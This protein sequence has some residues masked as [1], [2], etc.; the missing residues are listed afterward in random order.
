MCRACFVFIIVLIFSG[1]AAFSQITLS[2]PVFKGKN[3]NLMKAKWETSAFIGFPVPI[4]LTKDSSDSKFFLCLVPS[5][6]IS[7]VSFSKNL[8]VKRENGFTS[9]SVDSDKSHHYKSG[10]FKMNSLM[11]TSSFSLPIEFWFRTP[12]KPN[13]VLGG[14]FYVEYLLGGRFVNNYNDS[15]GKQ[16]IISKFKSN[17]EFYGFNRFQYGISLRLMIGMV[18]IYG[19]YSLAPLFK[20]N[21]GID[22]QKAGIGIS[23]DI[24]HKWGLGFF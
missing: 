4:Y 7:T 23:V 24:L 8:V 13:I 22:V 21:Q 6:H 2:Y 3:A 5:V 15:I 10:F 1:F 18:R 14:G 12:T 19:V 16:S 11:S 20:E 17:D 9:F